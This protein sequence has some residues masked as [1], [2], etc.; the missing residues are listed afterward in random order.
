MIKLLDAIP[1]E[2]YLQN[3]KISKNTNTMI[4]PLFFLKHIVFKS[5]S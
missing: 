2:E 5:M 3:F 4:K 1:Q